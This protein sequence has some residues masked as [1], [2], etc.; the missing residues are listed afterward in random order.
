MK[1]QQNGVEYLATLLHSSTIFLYRHAGAEK[2]WKRSCRAKQQTKGG[3]HNLPVRT[4]V[5]KTTTRNLRSLLPFI[6][7]LK[8]LKNW[9][10]MESFQNKRLV[11]ELFDINVYKLLNSGVLDRSHKSENLRAAFWLAT[12]HF[13]DL[14]LFVLT[15]THTSCQVL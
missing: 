3:H 1:Q 13:R 4:N 11:S 2:D 8:T 6:R 14:N 9:M 15:H 5:N 10:W 12:K 7:I